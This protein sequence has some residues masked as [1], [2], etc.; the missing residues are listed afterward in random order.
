VE[1]A[2]ERIPMDKTIQVADLGTG[3]GAIAL[4]IAR[5][6]KRAEV[7]ATD[8]SEAALAVARENAVALGVD[9]VTFYQGHWFEAFTHEPHV[10]FHLIASNPPYVHPQDPHLQQGDLRFEPASALASEQAGMADI[11]EIVRE[12]RNYLF[13]GGWLLLEHGYD[14][15][16]AVTDLLKEWG[17]TEVDTVGDLAQR[18]RVSLGRW[19]P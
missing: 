16:E 9:N 19:N 14:Q 2:L 12:A 17:Y 10:R 18:E 5:E 11:E 3:S 13:H 1:L 8:T 6:R 4:A 7:S 15:A